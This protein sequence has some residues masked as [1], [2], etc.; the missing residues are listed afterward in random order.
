MCVNAQLTN[1]CRASF[2]KTIFCVVRCL[3]NKRPSFQNKL[4]KVLPP[5]PQYNVDEIESWTCVVLSG[6]LFHRRWHSGWGAHLSTL[7][8]VA[9]G[10]CKCE[11]ARWAFIMQ[12]PVPAKPPK[13]FFN[14]LVPLS[15]SLSA[16]LFL[17]LSHT[18]QIHPTSVRLF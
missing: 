5:F 1:I 2:A 12:T 15:L 3:H 13:H 17:P 11:L 9:R 14:E 18:Q 6:R 7:C 16:A 10:L 4:L 8:W